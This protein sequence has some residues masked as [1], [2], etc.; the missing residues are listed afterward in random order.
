MWT[1]LVTVPWYV[2]LE[3]INVRRRARMPMTIIIPVGK[4]VRKL[5]AAEK[6][7]SAGEGEANQ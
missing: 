6:D 7:E 2:R 4:L 5:I 1:S 3:A